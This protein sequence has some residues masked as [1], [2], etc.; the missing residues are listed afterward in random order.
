[1]VEVGSCRRSSRAAFCSGPTGC[2]ITGSVR[3][4]LLTVLC[5]ALT[6]AVTCL[7]ILHTLVPPPASAPAPA[8]PLHLL[9]VVDP[10]TPPV[11]AQPTRP[12]AVSASSPAP[13]LSPAPAKVYDASTDPFALPPRTPGTPAARAGER[14]TPPRVVADAALGLVRTIEQDI[15]FVSLTAH[16]G[17]YADLR[18]LAQAAGAVANDRGS[19]PARS[20]VLAGVLHQA[21]DIAGDRARNIAN[22]PAETEQTRATAQKL[23]EA[24]MGLKSP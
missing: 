1:M 24:L 10:V 21:I 15:G 12:A 3:I 20:A 13:A 18:S 17:L 16:P 11:P 2:S 6:S 9:A 4:L 8:A 5:S 14:P 19:D 22:R 23:Q 7:S